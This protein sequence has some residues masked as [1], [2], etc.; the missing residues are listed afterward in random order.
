MLNVTL[1]I[2]Y[3]EEMHFLLQHRTDDAKRL[4]GYWGFFGGGIKAGESPLEAVCRESFEELDYNLKAPELVFRQ[5]F[6]LDNVKGY[7]HVYLDAFKG[8]KS[9]LKLQEGQ[10]LGWYTLDEIKDLKMIEHD[11]RAA[12]EAMLYLKDRKVE[13]SS[14]IRGSKK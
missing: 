2:L 7:M 10:N 8:D 4:P 1:F 3:D 13:K 6:S 12:E 5:N 11:K 14:F 9:V